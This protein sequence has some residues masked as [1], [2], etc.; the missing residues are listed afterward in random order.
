MVTSAYGKRVGRDAGLVEYE[1]GH[2]LETGPVGILTIPAN[3]P[4]SWSISDGDR[5]L[6]ELVFARAHSR[7]DELGA[8]PPYIGV[9]A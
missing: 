1:F 5:T 8:W 2:E 6:A 9:T 4:L 3:E 7:F